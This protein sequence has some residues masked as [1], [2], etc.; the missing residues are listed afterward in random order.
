MKPFQKLLKDIIIVLVLFALTVPGLAPTGVQ[1]FSRISP[2]ITRL[3]A[4][5][6]DRSLRLIVQKADTTN[7]VEDLVAQLGGKVI[8]D[9]RI[10][11]AVVVVMPASAA[12]TTWRQSIRKVGFARCNSN[13]IR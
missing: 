2:I 9:L 13:P 11:H 12:S 3:A 4:E 1:S 7:Q 5:T 6:P 8:K 10:I